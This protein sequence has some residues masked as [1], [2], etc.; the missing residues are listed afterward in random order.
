MDAESL[1]GDSAKNGIEHHV[2]E[3]DGQLAYTVM[4]HPGLSMIDAFTGVEYVE[5]T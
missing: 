2:C 4:Q 3:S 1:S 5:I